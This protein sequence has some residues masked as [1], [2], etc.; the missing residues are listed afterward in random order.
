MYVFFSNQKIIIPNKQ[1]VK[2]TNN[3]GINSENIAAIFWGQ[4][5]LTT[6]YIFALCMNTA[7]TKIMILIS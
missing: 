6:K 7:K 1:K 4:L 3:E 5:K 2:Q